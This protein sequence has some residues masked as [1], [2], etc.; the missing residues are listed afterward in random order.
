MKLD[1]DWLEAR[2][3]KWIARFQPVK[4]NMMQLTNKRIN[5]INAEYT[6]GTTLQ[7]VDKSKY[8]G[9]TIT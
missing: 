7:N 8:L 1:I 3:I 2:A 5:I 4:C 9:E 6:D